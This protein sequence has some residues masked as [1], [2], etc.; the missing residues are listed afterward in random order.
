MPP[1]KR[2]NT[3]ERLARLE[4]EYQRLQDEHTKAVRQAKAT[5]QDTNDTVQKARQ[6]RNRQKR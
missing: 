5:L 6:S 4:A 3:E 1:R 2:D